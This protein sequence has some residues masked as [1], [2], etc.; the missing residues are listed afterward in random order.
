MVSTTQRQNEGFPSCSSLVDLLQWRASHQP[1]QVA[2]RFL[3]DGGREPASLTYAQLGLRREPS[4][5]PYSA[6]G[7]KM[8]APYCF[9]HRA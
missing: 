8:I 1:N 6:Q 3:F 9:F 2:Y 5:R 4:P 7:P